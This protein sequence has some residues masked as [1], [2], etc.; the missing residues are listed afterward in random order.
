MIEHDLVCDI[1][2]RIRE[3]YLAHN[4]VALRELFDALGVDEDVAA[5]YFI[6]AQ[7]LSPNRLEA[8]SFGYGLLMGLLTR[9]EIDPPEL[10]DHD[11][12]ELLKG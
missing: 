5:H 11:L 4:T 8:F 12:A 9:N 7:E 1:A 6:H 2:D 10:T 3:Y